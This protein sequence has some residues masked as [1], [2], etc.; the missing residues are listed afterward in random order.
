MKSGRSVTV[1][2]ETILLPEATPQ[3]LPYQVFPLA[4]L[5][6]PLPL[7]PLSDLL[8]R[9]LCAE[10]DASVVLVRLEPQDSGGSSGN[11]ADSEPSLNGEFHL[12]AELRP[13]EAGFHSITL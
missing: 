9:S 13:T 8:A 11:G 3:P 12:P 6:D 4:Y 1:N 7:R 10:T 5:P 2:D